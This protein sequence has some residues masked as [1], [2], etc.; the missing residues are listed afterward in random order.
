MTA[1]DAVGSLRAPADRDVGAA[2]AVPSQ[3]TP[4]AGVHEIATDPDAFEAF[5][6]EH[7]EAIQRFVARRVADPHLAADLTADI[8][9]A[10]VD[11]ASGFRSDLGRP[12]AWLFGIARNV[13]ASELRR[14][15]R[16]ATATRQLSGRRH[17]E[18]DALIRIEERLAAGD[19]I[20]V[21]YQALGQV[22]RRDRALLELVYVDGLSIAEAAAVLGVKP[23]TARVRLHRGRTRLFTQLQSTPG[24]TDIQEA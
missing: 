9:L 4:D 23:G 19:Q 11:G 5:Y 17:I 2:S 6:V 7:I 10:A 21:L 1:I 22:R 20:R 16:E 13:L 15:A 24:L 14:G 18:D 8:F 3:S 12:I